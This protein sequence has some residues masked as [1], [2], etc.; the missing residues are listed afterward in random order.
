MIRILLVLL[1]A[2]AAL[3]ANPDEQL[4]DPVQEARA[5]ALGQELRCLQCAGET[6][7]GSNADFARD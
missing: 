3:A 5:V 4:A 1:W 7:E 2:G 6:I